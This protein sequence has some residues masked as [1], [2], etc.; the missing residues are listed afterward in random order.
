[1]KDFHDKLYDGYYNTKMGLTKENR[2]QFFDDVGRLQD[3]FRADLL[4]YHGVS[5]NPRAD[6]CYYLAWDFGH[7]SGLVEVSNMFSQFVG[8]IK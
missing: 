7:S 2:V 4:A 1:M 6:Q 5:K 8:L 3:E